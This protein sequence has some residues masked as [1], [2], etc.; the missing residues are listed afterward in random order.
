[1]V[2]VNTVS[3]PTA[4]VRLCLAGSITALYM[5]I[6]VYSVL[7][8][9][10]ATLFNLVFIYAEM[11]V[12]FVFSTFVCSIVVKLCLCGDT[13]LNLRDLRLFQRCDST[14]CSFTCRRRP[15]LCLCNMS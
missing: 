11:S 7:C 6:V 14:F 9:C 3:E 15:L 2:D 1:M 13:C 5:N 10:V 8:I 12:R 4:R